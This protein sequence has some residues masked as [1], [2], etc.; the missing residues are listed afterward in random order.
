VKV[1]LASPALG[2]SRE[3]MPAAL[4]REGPYEVLLWQWLALP[5]VA[6]LALVLGML[7][8]RLTRAAL[9]RAARRTSAPWDDALLARI[10]PP[11]ALAF[12]V[13]LGFAAVPWLVLPEP[14]EK[15]VLG[16]LR[17][18]T[19]V[20]FFWALA[21]SV[22]V[23]VQL[24]IASPWGELH[25]GMRSLFALAARVAKLLV[26]ATAAVALLSELGYPVASLIAGLGIGGLALA[27]AAQKT[28]ENLFGAFSIAADQPFRE[29][30]FVRIEDFVGTVELIGLRST[31]I[32]T[33]D[34]TVITFP[35]GR[36]ADMRLESFTARDRIRLACVVGV[37]YGTRRAQML[38]ILEGFERTLRGHPRIWREAV[39][40][41]FRELGASSLDIEVMA[42]FETAD[43]AEFQLYRQE[44]LLGF[45]RVVEAAGSSFA[46]PTRTVHVVGAAEGPRDDAAGPPAGSQA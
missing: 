40:V 36:L 30:D 35:N 33:L 19:L 42:W 14:A 38:Q 23:G 24:L 43:F 6:A 17:G 13:L 11:L 31:K 20:A 21:R 9:V 10:G 4:L 16:A 44:V 34:R 45:M 39:I 28:V 37:V 5:A 3:H 1:A 41:R 27:L 18:L 2:W 26:L 12:A 46:F 25:A 32:R 22:D 7:L 29:G 15:V 8:G